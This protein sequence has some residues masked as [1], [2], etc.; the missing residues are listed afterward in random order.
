MPKQ[1]YLSKHIKDV[2][3]NK[4]TIINGGA[5]LDF[6]TGKIKRAPKFFI[7]FGL[8]WLVR[9]YHEPY[10]LFKRYVIGNPVFL[11]RLFKELILNE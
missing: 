4:L 11:Y 9:L 8:E 7:K 3:T 6:M 5:I 1:E 2:Y 10:R